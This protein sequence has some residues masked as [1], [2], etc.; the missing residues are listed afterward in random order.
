MR[1]NIGGR[2]R[3][4]EEEILFIFFNYVS[5]LNIKASKKLVCCHLFVVIRNVCLKGKIKEQ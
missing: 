4:G 1:L 2:G 5:M 3:K